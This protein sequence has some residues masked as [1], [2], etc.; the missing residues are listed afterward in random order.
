MAT[1]EYQTDLLIIGGGLAGTFAAI[2]ARD[3]G[4][5]NLLL[6]DKAT[7]GRSG[8]S[9]FA[10]GVITAW[11]PWDNLDDWIRE[12]VEHGEY[13]ND[14]EWLDV[15]YTQGYPRILDLEAWGVELVRN[16]KGEIARALGRGQLGHK[17]L[18]NIMF[19][20]PQFMETMRQQVVKRR[21][22]ME[23]RVMVTDLLT[24]DNRVVGAVGF[25]PRTGDQYTFRAR[26]TI[27]AAGANVFKS[28]SIGHRNITGDAHG[29]AF[30]AG[31]R[32]T[33]FEFGTQNVSLRNFDTAGL[34][35]F[36]GTG[37][38]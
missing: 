32:H 20:G 28:I 6:V 34:N 7:V 4:V 29:M 21:I 11:F 24:R 38:R 1:R 23:Q 8:C 9:T 16:E 36:V 30:R 37:A 35:M 2:K 31:A 14:Q 25:N 27:L 15:L 33:C 12:T 10:A 13:L 22:P 18:R 5:E 3:A 19:H 17:A 26:T